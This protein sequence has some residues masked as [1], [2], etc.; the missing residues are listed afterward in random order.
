M[1][2][3]SLLAGLPALCAN[4]LLS[5]I[6]RHLTLPVGFYSCLHILLTLGFMA[7]ARIR[8]PESLRHQSPSE[9]G[10]AIGI[11]RVPEVRTLREKISLLASTG[12]P[13]A[14]MHELAQAWMEG[15]P[16]EAGYLYINGHVRI[17]HGDQAKLPLR[18]ISRER[19]CLRGTTDYWISDALG[20]PFFVCVQSRHGWA[21]RYPAQ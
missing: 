2:L 7:L 19:P 16:D 11:D 5:G 3:G 20:R 12:D 15:D 10:K 8:R 17:Y 6:G 14:W 9:L 21:G 18:Y 13:S 4:G 1:S